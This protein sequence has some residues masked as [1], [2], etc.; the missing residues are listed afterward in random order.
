MSTENNLHLLQRP[1]IGILVANRANGSALGL[2]VW[3]D[4]DGTTL[5]LIA[6]RESRKVK[7]LRD[8]PRASLL[9]VNDVGEPEAWLAFDGDLKIAE[10]GGGDLALRLA[11]R[12]WDLEHPGRAAEY[13]AWKE[14]PELFVLL[15]MAPDRIRSGK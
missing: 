2:P 9:V 15:E 7:R 4:W 12:Y 10:E 14:H 11:K 6:S 13:A 3:F 5:R 1:R 8:D